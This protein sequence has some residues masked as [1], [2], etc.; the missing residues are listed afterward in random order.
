M[1]YLIIL[2]GIIPLSCFGGYLFYK[3]LHFLWG[4]SN[5]FFYKVMEKGIW[6][7]LVWLFPYWSIPDTITHMILSRSGQSIEN[8]EG[9]AFRWPSTFRQKNEEQNY[10]D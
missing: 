3:T 2:F 7:A 1:T 4:L 9:W 6:R 5:L 8:G 10:N